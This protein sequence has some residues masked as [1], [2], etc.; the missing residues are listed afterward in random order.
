MRHQILKW[1]S[2]F[3]FHSSGAQHRWCTLQTSL[4][5]TLWVELWWVSRLDCLLRSAL[6]VCPFGYRCHFIHFRTHRN[7]SKV[8]HFSSVIQSEMPRLTRSIT[9]KLVP[10]RPQRSGSSALHTVKTMFCALGQRADNDSCHS[11][12]HSVRGT[13]EKLVKK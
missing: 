4:N 10:T 13:S 2:C 5:R 12:G 3:Y 8:Y 1:E 9:P 11:R 7:Q 6:R